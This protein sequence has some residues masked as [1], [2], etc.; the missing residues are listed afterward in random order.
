ML[1]RIAQSLYWLGRNISRA[2]HT[3]RT[4]DT[5]FQADVEASPDDPAS[6]SISWRSVPILMGADGTRSK[7]ATGAGVV[8]QLTTDTSNPVSIRSCVR[9]SREAARTLRDTISAEMWEVL[10]TFYLDL[11][12]TEMA[13]R[14]QA[15]PYSYY[16]AVKNHTALFWGMTAKTM[17]RDDA[18]SFLVAG[19]R[20][21][22]A[23]MVL[24]MLRV[25]LPPMR[26]ADDATRELTRRDG[27]AHALLRAVGGSQAFMRSAA[28]APTAVPVARFLLFEPDFPDSVAASVEGLQRG[29]GRAD[30]DPQG[31]P[32]ALRL[33][34]LIADLRLRNQAGLSYDELPGVFR[35]VQHELL[36]VDAE[37]ED[38][39]FAGER[40]T[41]QQHLGA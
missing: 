1:A 29:L 24:R 40:L 34:R 38:R 18:N 37:I 41:P 25:A 31:G 15:G 30:P 32:A 5:L 26:P 6:V 21:E 33:Q 36:R 39:Y 20:I 35:D 4:L 3:A 16:G 28:S 19:G 10:N 22:A 23:D 27:N 14:P 12:R 13:S 11:E 8:E 9:E 2:E 17:Q 7:A